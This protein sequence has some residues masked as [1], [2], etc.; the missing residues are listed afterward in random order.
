MKD[1]KNSKEFL[2]SEESS[3]DNLDES[4]NLMLNFKEHPIGTRN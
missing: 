2:E 1:D 4:T 3:D